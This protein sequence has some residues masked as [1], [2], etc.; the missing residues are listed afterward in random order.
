MVSLVAQ[1]VE[2]LPAMWETRVQSLGWED[3]LE[4]G[5]EIH[6]RILAWRSLWIEEPGRLQCMGFQRVGQDRATTLS[7]FTQFLGPII[8]SKL[9]KRDTAFILFF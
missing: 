1:T 2:N 8:T 6:S 7:H 3:P 5:M 4:K 9:G